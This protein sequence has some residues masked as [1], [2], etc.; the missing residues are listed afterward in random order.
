MTGKKI[1]VV[2][3]NESFLPI[4]GHG[5][6]SYAQAVSSVESS[7]APYAPSTWQS[8]I[9]STHGPTDEQ[10]KTDDFE[11]MHRPTG[12]DILEVGALWFKLSP[13]WDLTFTTPRGG[14]VAIDP[15]SIRALDRETADRIWH[16]NALMCKLNHT[17]PLAW[18]RPEEYAA[19]V[20]PGAHAA[21]LDLPESKAVSRVVAK[22]WT[23]A[24]VVAAIGHGV[25]GLLNVRTCCD[26]DNEDGGDDG[27]ESSSDSDS[28]DN[29]D[30]KSP[31]RKPRH[32]KTTRSYLLKDK[33]IACY[34]REEEEKSQLA[35]FLPF[36][37]EE[38]CK[39][40][41]ARVEKTKAFQPMV[42][43]DCCEGKGKS[44]GKGRVLITA[45]S[46]PSTPQ[47]IEKV[48]ESL[49]KCHK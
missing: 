27:D 42:V 47:F 37:L 38:Q 30:G 24:G 45:Q 3:T 14:A 21:M 16:E 6:R 26:G 4:H 11:A 46:W 44:S 15:L 7:P 35:K 20:L 22:I 2:L 49:K 36:S 31:H 23:H 40:R 8:P 18:I 17:V 19:V 32:G 25:A 39:K 5:S 34:T 12:V 13:E 48:C 10:F 29:E 1:L 41:G 43:V 33:R 28:D 9:T